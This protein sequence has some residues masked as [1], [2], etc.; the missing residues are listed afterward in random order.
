LRCN[1]WEA[2]MHR[3][4]SAAMTGDVF[5]RLIVASELMLSHLSSR[6]KWGRKWGQ[7]SARAEIAL[8][9]MS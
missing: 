3:T 4:R 1:Q 9:S 2:I 6:R 5:S 8:F 7:K